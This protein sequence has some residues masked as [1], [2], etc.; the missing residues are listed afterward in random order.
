[1]TM[2]FNVTQNTIS[3]LIKFFILNFYATIFTNQSYS[4]ILQ[5]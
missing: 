1:M 5:F 2:L 3:S 4:L